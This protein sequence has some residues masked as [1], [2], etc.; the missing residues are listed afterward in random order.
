MAKPWQNQ[1]LNRGISDA[2]GIKPYNTLEE[3]E[4]SPTEQLL[5]EI[6]EKLEYAHCS[7]AGLKVHLTPVM[8]LTADREIQD[9][10]LNEACSPLET[11]LTLFSRSIDRL[12]EDVS[13]IR[14]SLSI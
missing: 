4:V 10:A 11:K 13:F 3:K 7:M 1:A 5:D 2:D 6:T 12:V 9:F 14:K 8:R